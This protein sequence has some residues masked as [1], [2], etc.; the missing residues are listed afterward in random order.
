[1]R[2]NLGWVTVIAWQAGI[3]SAAYICGT[4]IQGLIELV[5]ESYVQQLWH[6][7]L[8]FYAVLF[9]CVFVNTVVGRALPEV[10][11]V[12][13]VVY[14]LGA[15]GVAVPLIYLAPHG[16]ARAVFTTFLNEGNWSSQTLS[17]FVGLS[18]VAYPFQGKR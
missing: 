8:L 5:D 16:S 18:G 3:C 9:A 14:I 2:L 13:F 6:G 4:L 17:W 1:M 11:S 12:L 10:E 7:T 15:F